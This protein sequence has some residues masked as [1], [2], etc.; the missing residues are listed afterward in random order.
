[1]TDDSV[2]LAAFVALG[3]TLGVLGLASAI[4]A[5]IFGGF[6]GGVCEEFHFHAAKRLS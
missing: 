3:M 1:M 6:G 2:K 5:E 4:L